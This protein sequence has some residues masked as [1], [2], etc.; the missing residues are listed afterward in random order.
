MET[1]KVDIEKLQMLN[2]RINQTIDALNQLR[3]S[4]HN[5]QSEFGLQHTAALPQQQVMGIPGYN[6]QA[7]FY[8]QNIGLQHTAAPWQQVQ[9]QVPVGFNVQGMR[10]VQQT[11]PVWAGIP[12]GLSHTAQQRPVDPYELRIAQ[13]FPYAFSRAPGVF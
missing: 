8:G 9:Q 5:Y 12:V 7:P 1:V 10:D 3:R 13:L 2:D 11:N 6:V 4:V